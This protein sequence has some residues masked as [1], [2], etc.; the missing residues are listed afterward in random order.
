MTTAAIAKTK[1][2]PTKNTPDDAAPTEDNVQSFR[3]TVESVVVAFI[4]AFLFRAFVAEAFVIP[5]G[6]MAPTLMGA[7]KDIECEYCGSQYQAGA[8][9]EFQ[10]DETNNVPV[11]QMGQSKSDYVSIA[12]TCPTCRA[13]NAYDFAENANHATFSGDR[14]LVSKFDYVLSNPKRW[15]VFV[16][17]YPNEARMNYIK[18]LVGLPGETLLIRDGDVYT[19]S[20]GSNDWTIA[21][22]PPH[23]IN[24]MRR[25]VSDTDFIA[26]AELAQGW[27][28]LW[29]PLDVD[30]SS[31][32]V[33]QAD[34]KWS[35]QLAATPTTQ[36][37]RY[38]HKFVPESQ[39]I[40][41]RKGAA[42]EIP[43]ARSSQ[44]I[45]DYLAYNSSYLVPRKLVFQDNGKL[46]KSIADGKLA[47][48][49]ILDRFDFQAMRHEGFSQEDGPTN[50]GIHWVG[51][52]V[53]EYDVEVQSASGIVHLDLVEFGIHFQCSI[54]V[55]TG[56]AKLTAIEDG[57]SIPLFTGEL[58]AATNVRGKGKYSLQMANVDDQIVLWVNGRVVEFS[59]PATYDSYSQRSAIER[60][61]YWTQQ[62]PLDAAPLAIGGTNVQLSVTRAAVYRD[63]YYIAVQR[64]RSGVYSDYDLNNDAMLRSA[65][66]DSRLRNRI[67]G[68]RAI[69]E[70][71]AHPEWW[72]ETNLFGLRGEL[73]YELEDDQFFPMG[74]NSAASSDARAWEGHNYV[75][76]K[77][78][79]GKALL[80]FWPHTW[81]RPIPF[82][83][84]F[85]RMGRIR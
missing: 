73:Q 36:W 4:L 35:A 64:P 30:A 63:I 52:L 68:E 74:D 31:W 50:D 66:P 53:G 62:D 32:T 75:E 9:R 51:D 71:Y 49:F 59:A 47:L 78:L 3:E 37:L 79:L 7:H 13:V 39:W 29:Q 23:K 24:A 72:S 69:A 57:K 43:D 27:P 54:D 1:N 45:T 38:Y 84:N 58:T 48:D 17:K 65:V 77:F 67:D 70:V 76:K 82:T 28:S 34:A 40:G 11:I 83:P 25:V 14:I 46:Q 18:R 19:K 12:S 42:L 85:G 6:S 60:R 61:P 20:A 81:N 21:R 55:A 26:P 44:L 8:S 5:T 80:V 33:D 56:E 15:D 2:T 41:A 22:K 10:Q 16:F